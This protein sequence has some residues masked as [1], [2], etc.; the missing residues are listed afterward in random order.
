MSEATAAAEAL[1]PPGHHLLV[2]DDDDRL[3]SL[4]QRFLV[5]Q[6]YHVTTAGTGVEALAAIERFTFDLLVL[7]VMLPDT[8]GFDLTAKLRANDKVPILLL[9]AR[10]E[11]D[12]RIRGLEVGADDY[13][14]KPFE[15]REL[16]LRVQRILD[17]A[18]PPG[19]DDEADLVRFGPFVFD[20]K[21]QSLTTRGVAVHLT[22]GERQLLAI[23]ARTPGI[24][25]ERFEL[26]DLADINGAD[27]AVDAQ[28]ARLRRK[29][30][31][32]PKQPRYLVTVRGRGYALIEGG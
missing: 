2:V 14:G 22:T 24:A 25:Y 17:R 1:A 31:D 32:D 12:D 29:I 3:R 16:V 4:L 15:P 21:R 28:V 19:A 5:A 23:L 9:T 7:D 27:R 20:R 10:K 8:T 30:E 18:R 11:V 13:L 26:T 6:G